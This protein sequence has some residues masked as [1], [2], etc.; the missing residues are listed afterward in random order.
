MLRGLVPGVVLLALS[1]HALNNGLGATPAL[2]WS[3]WNYFTYSINQTITLQIAE[4]LVT[5][6]LRDA[7]YTYLNI[8]AGS[9]RR[10]RGPNGTI[11][12]DPHKFPKGFRYLADR[13]HAMG[14][15]LGVYT[16]LSDGS[17]GTGP[18]S[19]GHYFFSF[20]TIA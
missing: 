15:K 7:G 20:F 12:A 16:D 10:T 2:G 5:T 18:G 1:S 9:L 11:T 17:C 8:D 4:A 6:G 14:L 19:K 3:S 13:L